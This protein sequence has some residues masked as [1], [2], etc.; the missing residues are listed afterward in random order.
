[1]KEEQKSV[2][3]QGVEHQLLCPR[4]RRVLDFSGNP[5]SFCAYCGSALTETL[6]LPPVSATPDVPTLSAPGSP[7]PAPPLPL[8]APSGYRL[9]RKLG[10]GGMGTVYE[11]E[12][13]A[14]GRHIA[15]KLIAPQFA[16]SPETIERFRQEGRIASILTHPRCVFVLAVDEEDGQPFIVM[17]LMPGATL[18]DLVDRHGPLPP[19]EA[20]ARI[21]DVIAGLQ[22]AHRLGFIHRDVKP[23]NCFLEADGRVKVGDFGLAKSLTRSDQLTRTGGFVGTPYFASPEQVRG[24]GLDQRT[25]IYSVAATLYYL[26]TGQPPFAGSSPEATLARIVSEPVPSLLSL[27]PDL[28]P[29]LDRVILRGLERDREQRW[30]DL[31]AFRQA[32]LSLTPRPLTPLELP[33]RVAAFLLDVA[34]LWFVLSGLLALAAPLLEMGWSPRRQAHRLA[35]SQT[36]GLMLFLV[37][38]TVLEWL[39]GCSLGKG[40]FGLRVCTTKWIDPPTWRHAFLRSATLSILLYVLPQLPFLVWVTFTADERLAE[41]WQGGV[42]WLTSFSLVGLWLLALPMRRGNG[43]LGLHEVLSGTRTARLVRPRHRPVLFGGGWLLSLL[44]GRRLDQGGPAHVGL[45]ERIGGFTV[46]GAL[47]WAAEE[48]V[49]LGEDAA[50]GRRV[51]L[52]LRPQT[53]PPLDRN[54]RDVSRPTRL[55]WLACGRQGDQQWDAIL[56]PTGCPLPEYIHSEGALEWVEARALLLDLAGELSAASSDGTLPRPLTP[57]QVWVQA[58][59]RAQ[60]ADTPLTSVRLE[61]TDEGASD[62]ERVLGLLRRV[63]VLAL[64]GESHSSSTPRPLRAAVPAAARPVVERLLGVGAPYETAE[65]VRTDLAAL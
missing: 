61:P 65:H 30:P 1:M 63:A 2:T 62:S 34:A 11:A 46:R 49:L 10:S 21:L 51:F 12:E 15:L 33:L 19:E 54:R 9:L 23:S 43:Y 52:W 48:K 28:S 6:A 60:L 16:R 59:G 5:P 13:C 22:E 18:M 31:E 47:K 58:D 24:E 39:W 55:R 44:A 37:Y 42:L 36:A 50:L 20:I 3:P 45:P 57:A 17:E 41:G 64:E 27:R 7:A 32:L 29:A 4:C 25:D 40:L 53:Q 35:I 38:F 56:A 8:R 26:L 14:S